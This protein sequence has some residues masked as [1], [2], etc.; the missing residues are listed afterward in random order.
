[1]KTIL[2]IE[3]DPSILRGLEEALTAE[4]FRVIPAPTGER[5]L[6]AA[7][8]DRVDLILLDLRLPDKDGADICREL[9]AGGVDAPIIVLSG[10]KAEADIVLLL[11]IGADEYVT[12]PFR[13][14]ELIARVRAMLRRRSDLRHD[15]E[16]YAFDDIMV[17]FRKHEVLR[18]GQAVPMT[19]REMEVLKHFFLHE[20]EVITRD[21]LL[22]A[23]WGYEQFP[24]TRTVDNYILSL[25]KKLERHP[26]EPVYFLTVHASGYKF[27][28]G[29]SGIPAGRPS[30]G[31]GKAAGPGKSPR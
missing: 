11:E 27:V 26:A 1:M 3:D 17:D 15:L 18:G 28:R 19:V 31:P 16:D 5:G 6:S 22:N 25:R 20:G 29:P 4:H 9:R 24:T 13:T 21:D 30:R 12:K 8:R 7:G 14:R 23:V 2:V 10:V